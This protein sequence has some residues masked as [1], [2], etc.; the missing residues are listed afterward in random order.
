VAC[1]IF[2]PVVSADENYY[3]KDLVNNPVLEVESPPHDNSKWK[4]LTSNGFGTETN[5]A[6]R[7][8]AIYNDEL[9]IGTQNNKLPKLF[10][11]TCPEL[12]QVLSQVL[13]N[14]LPNFLQINN[15]FKIIFRIA[16]YIRNRTM[17]KFL[18]LV[19][20]RSEGCEIWK[21]NYSTD[22][23]TQIVGE[24]SIT[25]MK[26]GFN[27]NFN[28]LAGAIKE[29]NNKLYVGTANTPIGSLQDP[30]RKGCE[31][32]RYNGI[33]W[34][35]V[36]GHI[37]PIVKG[38]FGNAE[39]MAISDLEVFDGYLYAGTMNWDFT[40]KGGC[41][42]WR[43]K[44]G[45]EW[46]QVVAHGFKP[47]MSETDL[48]TGV[49]NTYLWNMEVFRNQ[50]YVGTFNSCYRF[51]INAGIGGQLWR[52]N[53]G[54]SW[55]KIP[56]PNGDGFGEKENYGIR[57]MTVYNNELY[58]GTAANIVHDKGFEIWKYDG[59]NWTPVVSDDVPGVKPTNVEY[60]GFGN[61][62]NKYVWSMTV[63]SDNKLWVGTANG[64]F[65]NLFEPITE[66]C[67]IWCFNGTKWKPIV[68][69]GNNEMPNGF[70][71]INNEGIRSIIEYPQGSGNIVVG[72]LK[73]IS[74]RPLVLQ[75]GFELWMRS[76]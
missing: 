59:F 3:Q 10:Q 8:I 50:L 33:T 68:K 61:P 31:I 32:W 20:S 27:Y 30:H 53:D 44:D 26:S 49:T 2:L 11:N 57:A 76:T 13:P 34:E 45:V 74:T 35:Q 37:A 14:R 7:G 22:T 54:K 70:G 36:V 55:E 42:V 40:L 1:L 17:R 9:Y 43:T 56:L 23:L 63:T 46:E 29:F 65:V 16:H 28:C 15:R 25:G 69:N 39:N 6:S 52:T 5:L 73:L 62:L 41:E 18:H 12:L 60:S 4:Q 75:E 51:I 48:L 21:Y 66:G 58:I 24:D 72:T 71:D 67:E 47:Y 38:G 64:K 19:I